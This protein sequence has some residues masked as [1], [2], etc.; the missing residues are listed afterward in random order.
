MSRNIYKNKNKIKKLS[1]DV[2]LLTPEKKHVGYWYDKCLGYEEPQQETMIFNKQVSEIIKKAIN[3]LS[4]REKKIIE[5]LY[6][7]NENVTMIAKKQK[8]SKTR[9]SQIHYRALRKLK[10]VLKGGFLENID[11]LVH[12]NIVQ[13]IEQKQKYIL[14]S[15]TNP[16]NQKFANGILSF[17]VY[18]ARNI[19]ISPSHYYSLILQMK[20]FYHIEVITPSG[21]YLDRIPLEEF[22]HKN[23][24]FFN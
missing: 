8:L 3:S 5:Q 11:E 18:C 13:S 20:R 14:V 12:Y 9:I 17:G 22:R 16:H 6:F 1:K 2:I 10:N 21:K 15:N 7:M 23:S 24:Y 4:D 19:C